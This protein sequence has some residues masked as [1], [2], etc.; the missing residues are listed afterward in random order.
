ML[1]LF[2]KKI[3]YELEKDS[4][5][6]ISKIAKKINRS[7]EFVNFRIHRLKEEGILLG[8][9][10][11]VDMSKFGYF[12][13][14]V[15]IKWQNMTKERKQEFYNYIKVMDNVWTTTVLHGKWDFAFFVGV[16]SGN[17]IDSFH[18]LWDEI[19]SRYKENISESKIAIYAPIH[20]FN[21]KFF[22]EGQRET[23]ER[24]YGN[25]SPTKFDELDE[26][27]INAYAGNVDKP[28][29]E[30]AKQIKVNSETLRQR[31][32][33]LEKKKVIVGYKINLDLNK[34]GYQ[35]YRVDFLLNSVSRNKELFNY[36]KFH[37]YFYQINKSIGGADFEAEIVVKDLNQLLEILEEVMKKFS[38]IIKSYDYMG[39]SEFPTLSIVP[40]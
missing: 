28:L 7:K 37:K 2:D 30:I 22:I 26:K 10:A 8:Y 11:I 15:Y 4:S 12:T 20:N 29:T 1:D 27:I 9:S 5:Q 35:G 6:P 38:D 13:F 33:L 3:I 39:Y 19:Q 32:K 25:G 23:I 34:M 18:K 16:K 36:L 40:D 24:I 21:K 14:R 31:I 17:Y